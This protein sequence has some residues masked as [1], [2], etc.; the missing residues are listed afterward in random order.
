MAVERWDLPMRITKTLKL[1][2]GKMEV[3]L[4]RSGLLLGT[5][6]IARLDGVT[7]TPKASVC[8][9]G[10]LLE[11]GAVLECILPASA[12]LQTASLPG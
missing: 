5:G 10:V 7:L 8:S 6:C 11:L 3:L 4:V 12:G 9:L 1:N 2:P